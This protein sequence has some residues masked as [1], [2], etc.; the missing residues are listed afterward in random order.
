MKGKVLIL[1]SFFFTTDQTQKG[2]VLRADTL[3]EY[4]GKYYCKVFNSDLDNGVM[5]TLALLNICW[6]NKNNMKD[7]KNKH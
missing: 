3:L 4:N 5:M 1:T 7:E 2:G 6:L